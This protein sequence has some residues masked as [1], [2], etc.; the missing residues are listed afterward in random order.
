MLSEKIVRIDGQDVDAIFPED[1]DFPDEF[2]LPRQKVAVLKENDRTS[3]T[4]R[5]NSYPNYT[6]YNKE[7]HRARM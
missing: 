4:I 6:G 1:A 5:T 3:K 7:Q 2:C